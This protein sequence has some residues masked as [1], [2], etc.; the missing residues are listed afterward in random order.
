MDDLYQQELLD[1]YKNPHNFG[2]LANP[3]C[4]TTETNSSCGDSLTLKL[5]IE[6]DVVTDAKFTGQGCA[7]SMAATS[8]LTDYVL[9]KHV[10]EIKK[11]D[12][13]FMQELIGSTISPGRVKCLTLGARALMKLLNQALATTG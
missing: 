8:L 1:H 10:D 11:I 4:Q 9:G 6:K 2:E 5:R 3:T 13:E 7:V 12:F